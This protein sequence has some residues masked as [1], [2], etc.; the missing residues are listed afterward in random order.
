MFGFGQDTLDQWINS[1][2]A[3]RHMKKADFQLQHLIKWTVVWLLCSGFKYVSQSEVKTTAILFTMFL[4]CSSLHGVSDWFLRTLMDSVL[5]WQLT[6]S[7]W[8]QSPFT[9]AS[10]SHQLLPFYN[11]LTADRRMCYA[12]LPQS[13]FLVCSKSHFLRMIFPLYFSSTLKM[14]KLCRGHFTFSPEYVKVDMTDFM[15]N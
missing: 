2:V 5:P 11:W 1:A 12:F 14:T 15:T 10:Q 4:L 3:E 8:F 9:P 6:H 7:W 13:D